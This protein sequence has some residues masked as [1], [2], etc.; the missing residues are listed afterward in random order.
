M[1]SKE[2]DKIVDKLL[3][4]RGKIP[5]YGA[6]NDRFAKMAVYELHKKI[7]D[8]IWQI[9]TYANSDLAGWIK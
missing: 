2:Y 9:D 7:D 3:Q 8:L 1:D 6:V 4:F 5:Q